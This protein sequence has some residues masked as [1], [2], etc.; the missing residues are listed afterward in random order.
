MKGLI[1]TRQIQKTNIHNNQTAQASQSKASPIPL[2]HPHPII[3][4]TI[5]EIAPKTSESCV[6]FRA[7]T[8]MSSGLSLHQFLFVWLMQPTSLLKSC[9]WGRKTEAVDRILP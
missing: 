5:I 4:F 3:D 9:A 8:A 6:P 2:L 1:L 7:Q